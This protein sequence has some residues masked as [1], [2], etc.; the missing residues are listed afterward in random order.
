MNRINPNSVIV[1]QSVRN[2]IIEYF[3]LI[4]DPAACEAFGANAVINY[5]EDWRSSDYPEPVFTE[6]ERQVIEKFEIAWLNVV[7]ATPNPMPSWASLSVL[8]VWNQL[9]ASA[10]FALA[11]FQIRGYLPEDETII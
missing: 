1:F 5:W 3:D 11:V 8:P 10:R 4:S 7:N 2:R 6:D 9:I